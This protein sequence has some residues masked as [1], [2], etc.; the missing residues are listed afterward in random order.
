M[1]PDAE[2]LRAHE[3]DRRARVALNL[4]AEPGDVRVSSLVAELG[5]VEL[6]RLLTHE[7]DEQGISTDIAARLAAVDADRELEHAARVGLRFVVPGDDEWP[8]RL[9]DLAEAPGL[10]ERGGVPV[11]LWVRGPLRLDQLSDSVAVV[12]SRAATTYG[13]SVAGEI[14]GVSGLA[15]VTVVS[16]GAFGIDVAAHRGALAVDAPTVAV[17]ACG[18]DRVYPAAHRELLDHIA[19]TGAVVSEG[20]PGCAPQRIRFLARNRIIAALTR[21]TV[22]VEAATRSGALNT[23][24]WAGRLNR[25]VMGV[26]GPVSSVSSVGVHEQIRVGAMTLVTS[27]AEV[28]ELVGAAGEHLVVAPRGPTTARDRLTSRQRQVLDAVPVTSRAGADSIARVAGLG[29]LEVRASLEK[30]RSAAL[31]EGSETGWRLA[32]DGR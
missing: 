19:A 9:D 22:V 26:P 3:V 17:L 1:S 32:P 7:R 8:A 28:L 30:L 2:A 29:I 31:V 23:A 10:H 12:G 24:N 5:A 16:G 25:V 11:G 18:A 6:H 20:P 15:G 4:L 13:A 27:G 14:G 21:G